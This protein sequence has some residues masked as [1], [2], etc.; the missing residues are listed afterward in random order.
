MHLSTFLSSAT[1]SPGAMLVL[2]KYFKYLPVAAWY[3]IN[4]S[5]LLY[6]CVQL[7]YYPLLQCQSVS[8][9]SHLYFGLLYLHSPLH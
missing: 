9:L 5:P 3:S 2:Q 8:C 1:E 4:L 7:K 6:L